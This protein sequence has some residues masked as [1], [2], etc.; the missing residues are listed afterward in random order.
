MKI[1]SLIQIKS[2]EVQED[3]MNKMCC[4]YQQRIGKRSIAR[5]IVGGYKDCEGIDCIIK[6]E[7]EPKELVKPCE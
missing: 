4:S 7:I 6:W 1:K 3:L 5:F 2:G